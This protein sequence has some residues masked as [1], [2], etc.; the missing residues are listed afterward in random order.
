MYIGFGY[1]L[2][3]AVVRAWTGVDRR[4]PARIGV[5]RRA[6]TESGHRI[7]VLLRPPLDCE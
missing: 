3:C 5:D 7:V 6:Y 4:G 1:L 2:A